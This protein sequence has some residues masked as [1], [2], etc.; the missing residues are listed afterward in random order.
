MLPFTAKIVKNCLYFLLFFPLL[1]LLI[2]LQSGFCPDHP[3]KT[4]EGRPRRYS[5]GRLNMF[6]EEDLLKLVNPL[7]LDVLYSL[8]FQNAVLLVLLPP[9]WLLFLSS[10]LVLALLPTSLCWI[11]KDSGLGLLVYLYSLP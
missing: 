11:P 5:R 1:S 7:F 9:L 8:G 2:L 6:S 4:A 3:T 10:F